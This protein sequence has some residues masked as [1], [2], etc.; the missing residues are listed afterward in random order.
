MADADWVNCIEV[1]SRAAG[2]PQM[3]DWRLS[4]R[5]WL[6][7]GS[8]PHNE[9][10]LRYARRIEGMTRVIDGVLGLIENGV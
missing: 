1:N 2:A 8:G 6:V 9:L 5:E 4:T 3:G 7:G 10:W